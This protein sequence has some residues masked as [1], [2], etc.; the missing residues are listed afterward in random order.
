METYEE[1][2]VNEH[3]R[4]VH[5]VAN[6]FR[7]PRGVDY[8]DLV[9][10]GMIGLLQAI[11][12]FDDSLGY[13]FSTFAVPRILSQIARYIKNLSA[14]KRK[15]NVASIET[16]IY[17]NVSL[18]VLKKSS[19]NNAKRWYGLNRQRK[20]DLEQQKSIGISGGISWLHES[21]LVGR[22]SFRFWDR[23]Q[24]AHFQSQN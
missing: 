15:G 10:V 12:E 19:V 6:R 24:E 2:M 11:R 17:D 4:L 16:K 8:E 3:Q 13:K 1:A 7:V 21:I 5:M 18:L 23:K 22:G 14:V 9:Q 20:K